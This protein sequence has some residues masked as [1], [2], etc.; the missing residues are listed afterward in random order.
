MD[1]ETMKGQ[2]AFR[3]KQVLDYDIDWVEVNQIFVNHWSRL[4]VGKSKVIYVHECH[5]PTLEH[6]AKPERDI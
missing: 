2:L 3:S 6:P 5:R 4:I 1:F